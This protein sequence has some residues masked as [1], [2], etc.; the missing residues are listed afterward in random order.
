MGLS[1]L[2]STGL[3]IVTIF[4]ALMSILFLVGSLK[5]SE[6]PDYNNEDNDMRNAKN[7]LI[8][9][10]VL[11]FIATGVSLL[12]A[13][14]YGGHDY[15]NI[16]TEVPHG[17]L[18]FSALVLIIISMIYAFI[19]LNK[20]NV[21][22]VKDTNGSEQYIWAGLLLGLIGLLT[23]FGSAAWRLQFN[24]GKRMVEDKVKQGVEIVQKG[25]E[26]VKEGI[27]MAENKVKSTLK[28]FDTS[29]IQNLTDQVKSSVKSFVSDLNK[30][31]DLPTIS[32]TL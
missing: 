21:P 11:G 2:T 27:K 16:S 31:S 12:L 20:I 9:A 19:S 29:K 22:E 26:K 24:I 4:V 3:G 30:A 8:T 15:W 5:I 7:N 1:I 23:L 6:S 13:F 10:Y 25:A 17:F 32:S 18:M 14:L 28:S